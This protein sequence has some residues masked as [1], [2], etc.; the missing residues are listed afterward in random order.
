MT[1]MPALPDLDAGLADLIRSLQATAPNRVFSATYGGRQLWIKTVARPR[2]RSSVL[3][4][5][6]I[7]LLSGLPMLQPAHNPGGAKGLAAEAATIRTVEA[8]GFP[9]PPVVGCTPDWL[10]LGDAGEA[11]EAQLNGLRR[12]DPDE[13]WRRISAAGLLL[14]RLHAAGL[15]HGGAQIRNFCWRDDKPGLID[16]EDHAL[17]GMTLAERQARDLLLFLY[18]LTRYDTAAKDGAPRLPVLAAALL[19]NAGTEVHDAL[20]KLRGRMAWLL[21]LARLIAPY[22]GRDVRQAVAADDALRAVLR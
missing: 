20:R 10:V 11:L 1:V 2:L 4:Q 13:C 12:S 6:T 22:A 17:P 9:V 14:G 3:L 16:F 7:A 5:K 19:G 15:W 8:A 18:S 21:D